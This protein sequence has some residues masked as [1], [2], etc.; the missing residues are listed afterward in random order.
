M[1]QSGFEWG[2]QFVSW[3]AERVTQ[4]RWRGVDQIPAELREC[5]RLRSLRLSNQALERLENLPESLEE[6]VVAGNR[7][8][9]LD[10]LPSGLRVLRAN[11][12]R[13]CWLDSLPGGLL[14]LNLAGNDLMTWLPVLP[15][16]LVVLCVQGCGLMALPELPA[17][18]R[19]LAAGSNPI[20]IWPR[21]PTG[22]KI[23]LADETGMA[24]NDHLP[25]LPA[26]L[27]F[28]DISD[29]SLAAVP[30]FGCCGGASGC[31]GCFPPALQR[32]DVSQNPLAALPPLPRLRSLDV[33]G[34]ALRELPS[35]PSSLLR[36]SVSSNIPPAP[37]PPFLQSFN[38]DCMSSTDFRPWARFLP[39]YLIVVPVACWVALAAAINSGRRA[40]AR[41]GQDRALA[42][43]VVRSRLRQAVPEVT[44]LV[45]QYL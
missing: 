7:L 38:L 18:L 43:L 13:I 26:G 20:M 11:N 10:G 36:L 21:L 6:L 29:N 27:E 12:N 30:C 41:R 1:S 44:C 19:D 3:E 39:P 22:L 32:L 37:L 25:Q 40:A 5:K 24:A 2:L 14:E 4:G 35:L 34:T 8:M 28:L 15:P 42:S 17:T 23:L 45:Q 33:H 31:R 9:G 16:A